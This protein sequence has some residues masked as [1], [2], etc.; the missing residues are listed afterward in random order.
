MSDEELKYPVGKFEVPVSYNTEDIQQW[1]GV[2]KTLPAKLRHAIAHLNDQQLDTPYRPGGWTIRQVVHHMADSHMNSLIR[3]KWT[4]T[5]ENTTIKAYDQTNWAMLPDYRLP[6]E[7]S[8]N[9][10]KGVHQHM[11]ALFESFT[12][13]EWNRTFKHPETGADVSLKRNLALYAWHSRHHLA[14][15]TNTVKTF[16]QQEA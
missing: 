7:S 11:V 16:K 14:H 15:V 2:I 10:L 13:T 3:F 4:L 9:I 6:V 8:L 12:E 5:E 1:I